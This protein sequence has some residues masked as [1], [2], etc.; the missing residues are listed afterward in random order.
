MELIQIL[1]HTICKDIIQLLNFSI[2]VNYVLQHTS[3]CLPI[4]FNFLIALS[5]PDRRYF[6]FGDP[7]AHLTVAI[8]TGAKQ[9]R[10]RNEEVGTGRV[11]YTLLM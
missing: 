8:D 6:I 10:L 9:R 4:T 3:L 2:T 5:I 1:C 7:A 11:E